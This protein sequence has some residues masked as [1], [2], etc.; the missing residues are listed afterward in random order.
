MTLHLGVLIKLP[1]DLV[2]ALDERILELRERAYEGMPPSR[3]SLMTGL[4]EA[5]LVVY[6]AQPLPPAPL[7]RAA[8]EAQRKARTRAYFTQMLNKA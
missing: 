8:A 1:V 7:T 6:L 3:T 2:E 4:A 5:A